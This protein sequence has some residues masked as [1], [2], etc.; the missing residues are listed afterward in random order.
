[1]KKQLEKLIVKNMLRNK[2]TQ[3]LLHLISL[4]DLRIV[5]IGNRYSHF[6]LYF[7]EQGYIQVDFHGVGPI[8]YY[9]WTTNIFLDR[10]INLKPLSY[11]P[12]IPEGGGF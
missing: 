10:K 2:C 1:M 5:G 4:I 9:T 6:A 7:R 3:W 11:Q 12:L 8:N